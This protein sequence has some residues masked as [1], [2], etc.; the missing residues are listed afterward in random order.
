MTTTIEGIGVPFGGPFSGRDSYDTFFTARTNLGLDLQPDGG[1]LLY[2][3]GLD[4]T[5]RMTPIGRWEVIETTT[6][7]VRVRAT[8][9]DGPFHDA[10]RALLDEGALA[11]SPG[12]AEHSVR[13]NARTGEVI[14]WPLWEISLTPNPSNS[15]AVVSGI[16]GIRILGSGPVVRVVAAVSD[17]APAVRV[18]RAAKAAPGGRVVRVRPTLQVGIFTPEQIRD[19]RRASGLT[20]R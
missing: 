9:A 12:S 16:G 19:I 4:P 5:I 3:H 13:Y 10:I 11:F 20:D 1:P 18:V 17:P 7:G 8:I 2:Q 6:A 14:D 15:Y